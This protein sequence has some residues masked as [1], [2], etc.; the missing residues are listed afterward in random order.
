MHRQTAS[1][2]ACNSWLG[3]PE[4]QDELC[5]HK[6]HL[7]HAKINAIIKE[8]R[9]QQEIRFNSCAETFH[10]QNRDK[11]EDAETHAQDKMEATKIIK[12]PNKIKSIETSKQS[13]IVNRAGKY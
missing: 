6:K 2:L 12:Q 8:K 7:L 1:I 11:T 5:M 13:R 3:W 9:I 4:S 10:L